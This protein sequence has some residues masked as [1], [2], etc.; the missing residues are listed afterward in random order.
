MMKARRNGHGKDR[1]KEVH[2]Q[3]DIRGQSSPQALHPGEQALPHPWRA[4]T[5]IET[6]QIL[7]SSGAVEDPCAEFRLGLGE[8]VSRTPECLSP[9]RG[10][11]QGASRRSWPSAPATMGLAKDVP[12][13]MSPGCKGRVTYCKPG[14]QRLTQGPK[15][16]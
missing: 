11:A 1:D 13:A 12:L 15:F 6:A 3:A 5:G 14:A 2:D 16:E 9:A 7:A 10:L 4:L 8:W